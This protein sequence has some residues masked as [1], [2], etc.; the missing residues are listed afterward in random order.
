MIV[1]EQILV[2]RFISNPPYLR[3]A[4]L[5]KNLRTRDERQ[6]QTVEEVTGGERR[7]ERTFSGRMTRE[8]WG[9]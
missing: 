9:L 2:L 5:K 6:M 1:H 3:L 4:D 8:T 7:P